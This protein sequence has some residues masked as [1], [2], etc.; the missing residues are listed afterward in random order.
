MKRILL[1]TLLA[2]SVQTFAQNSP[3][4]PDAVNQDSL[5]GLWPDTVQNLPLANEGVYYESYVQ[6]KTPAV[7]SE[8]PDVPSQFSS[9][10]IDSIGLVE[11]VGLPSGIQM[12][13]NEPSC[14]YP[15]NSIGCINIFGTTNAVGV[16]DLEFKVDG[17]VTAPIIGVVSMS[18]AVGD[19]VYLTGY[20]LVVNGSG[21]DVELIHS[22]TFEVLQNIPNPFTDNTSITYNLIQQRNVLF[23]VYDL[24]GAKVMEQQFVA[25]SGTNTI[26]LSANELES[27]IY[28]YTLSNGDEVITKRMIVA[29]K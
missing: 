10:N 9:L 27:G 24:M 2:F 4:V 15:G 21:A 25:K 26:E 18:V 7:A 5:F 29:R 3:C 20:K 22:N 28:F 23:S 12:S 19:Y 1:F 17:W 16:H 11:A 13:C 14:I 8:V 6:L